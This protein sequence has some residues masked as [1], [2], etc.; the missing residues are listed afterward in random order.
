MSFI[1]TVL[2]LSLK[3]IQSTTRSVLTI[4]LVLLLILMS[5]CSTN[6]PFLKSK[7]EQ[8]SLSS[9]REKELLEAAQAAEGDGAVFIAIPNP[10][11]EDP[12]SVPKAA[13]K[14]FQQIKALMVDKRWLDAETGL[15]GMTELYPN[16]SGVYTNLGIVYQNTAQYEEAVKALTFAIEKNKFNFDAYTVLGTVYREQGKFEDAEKTYFAAL[17]LWPHHPASRR[18][19]GIVYDLYMGRWD[20]ALVQYEM[21]QKIAGGEDREL[22]GWIVD[23]QRRINEVPPRDKL[24][25]NNPSGTTVK[26]GLVVRENVSNEGES[27]E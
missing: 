17:D 9:Q 8:E 13:R 27:N 24:Q 3:S 25:E 20:D 26:D 19:L 23:L 12:S 6:I 21:S 18:N 22:K 10:Y 15:L 1:N 2:N 7:A 16:L 11:L 5:A 4:T 14:D